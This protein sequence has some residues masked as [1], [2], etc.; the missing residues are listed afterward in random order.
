LTTY[1]LPVGVLTTIGGAL[2]FLF[3]LKREGGARK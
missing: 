2:F 1:E 3:L